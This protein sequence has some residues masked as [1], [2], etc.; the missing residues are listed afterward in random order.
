M[1]KLS[2]I[3]KE[4]I[5]RA[6]LFLRDQKVMLDVDLTN[7]YGVKTGRIFEFFRKQKR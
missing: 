2:I 6:I 3:P 5:Y 1:E 7:M 4:K